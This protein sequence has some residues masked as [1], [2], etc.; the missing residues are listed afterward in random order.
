M[1]IKKY[2][3]LL[4]LVVQFGYLNASQGAGCDDDGDEDFFIAMSNLV[5]QLSKKPDP[6][7]NFFERKRARDRYAKNRDAF[8][9]TED[10]IAQLPEEEQI[11]IRKRAAQYKNNLDKIKNRDAKN[12]ALIISRRS[13]IVQLPKVKRQRK[14]AQL[15]KKERV[16]MTQGKMAQLSK[17]VVWGYRIY[18]DFDNE[19]GTI[20]TI[21]AAQQ[22]QEKETSD[23]SLNTKKHE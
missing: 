3:F 18:V 8:N 20:K 2:S 21:L 11:V 22:S 19:Y 7:K 15:P 9:M 13:E 23:V 4:L 10:E 1:K 17:E 14:M 6:T 16:M 5:E 12:R